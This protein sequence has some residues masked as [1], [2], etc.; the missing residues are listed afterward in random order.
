MSKEFQLGL[1][2]VISL[3]KVKFIKVT[4]DHSDLNRYIPQIITDYQVYIQGPFEFITFE[5]ISIPQVFTE[6]NHNANDGNGGKQD[7]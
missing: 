6:P 3:D 7:W 1:P 5:A 4:R 2:N